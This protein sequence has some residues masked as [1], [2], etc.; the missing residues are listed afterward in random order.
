MTLSAFAGPPGDVAALA[1]R[2]DRVRVVVL[3]HE[4]D[5]L[6][7]RDAVE[8]GQAGQGGAS[9]SVAA[10]ASDL[11]PF[12]RGALPGFGQ[13]GEHLGVNSRQA[14]KAGTGPA[15]IGRL[16]P[17]PRTSLPEGRR[18]IPGAEGSH[19]SLT[20]GS[21]ASPCRAGLVMAQ[22]SLRY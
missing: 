14:P 9:A 5:G 4:R 6:G 19:V 8:D 16:S 10:R 15:G 21:Y 12:G 1:G 13:G 7:A 3:A 17:R 20:G 11:D 22:Y 18:K 2:L